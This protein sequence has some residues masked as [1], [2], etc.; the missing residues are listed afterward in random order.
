MDS[1]FV[2][3]VDELVVVRFAEVTGFDAAIL[4]VAIVV[5]TGE[6]FTFVIIL[7]V[8]L[9]LVL[10][11]AMGSVGVVY[12]VYGVVTFGAVHSGV[13][14]RLVVVLGSPVD[15]SVSISL[16][17]LDVASTVW[18]D[19]VFIVVVV[20]VILLLVSAGIVVSDVMIVGVTDVVDGVVI[21]VV[22]V[23]VV[24]VVAVVGGIV[25]AG[26]VVVG[27]VVVVVVVVVVRVSVDVEVVDVDE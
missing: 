25:V 4:F 2:E 23:M 6:L 3:V 21:V 14:N 1:D 13:V 8:A 10:V 22:G 26:F 16:V 20:S 11:C 24:G 15:F 12:V 7:G 19:M 9:A 17:T 18:F 27:V 5:A